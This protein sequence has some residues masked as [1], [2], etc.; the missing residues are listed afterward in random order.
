MGLQN[1]KGFKPWFSPHKMVLDSDPVLIKLGK[2]RDYIVHNGMLV[3]GS[4]AMAGISEGRGL[5]LG[6]TF[7][8]HPNEDSDDAILDFTRH[9]LKLG[10]PFQYFLP[11]EESMPCIER[12]W[13]VKEISPD[14]ILDVAWSAWL[15]VANVCSET[16]LWIGGEKLDITLPCRHDSTKIKIKLYDR[17]KLI[18]IVKSENT[19]QGAAS[20]SHS[21]GA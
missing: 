19:E 3:P 7:P 6:T 11:D 18:K 12:E 16:S 14:N 9:M 5:K 2:T 13:I 10:D 8:I 21:P 4:K 1:K 17:D 20:N 15:T